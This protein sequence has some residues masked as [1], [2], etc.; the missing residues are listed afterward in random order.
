MERRDLTF[1][2]LIVI[3]ISAIFVN[4]D[5][6]CESC[7]CNVEDIICRNQVVSTLI[8]YSR[9]LEETHYQS[10]VDLRLN[11][12]TDEVK[13]S[14]LMYV[15]PKIKT[16]YLGKLEKCVVGI[17]PSVDVHQMCNGM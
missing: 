6:I 7:D 3:I 8:S 15:F 12:G 17:P 13:V 14:E 11:E 16:L 2:A 9:L 10:V 4:G 1:A 5:V